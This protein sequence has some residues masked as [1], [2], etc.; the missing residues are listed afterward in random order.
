MLVSSD[1]SLTEAKNLE[2][3]MHMEFLLPF[4]SRL[5]ISIFMESVSIIKYSTSH[6]SCSIQSDF[7]PHS[8]DCSLIRASCDLI[9]LLCSVTIAF[10]LLL[11][12]TISSTMLVFISP[13]A[14]STVAT[15]SSILY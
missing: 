14:A 8:S 1:S 11:D 2:L 9:V 13:I 4:C 5:L 7:F 6:S 15:I 12:F 3:F 10:R